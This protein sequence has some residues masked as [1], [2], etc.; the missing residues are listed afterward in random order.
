MTM[1]EPVKY[2]ASLQKELMRQIAQCAKNKEVLQ[3][4]LQQY[5]E[6]YRAGLLNQET[7]KQQLEKFLQGKPASYWYGLYE[8]HINKCHKTL[9]YC[10]EKLNDL[11]VDEPE[12]RKS[13][14]VITA[15]ALVALFIFVGVIAFLNPITTITGLFGF[16]FQKE[17]VVFEDGYTTEG[18]KWADIKGSRVY[19]RCLKIESEAPFS[20]VRV[21]GKITSAINRDDLT[22]NLYSNNKDEPGILLGSCTVKDYDAVWKFCSIKKLQQDKGAYWICAAAPGGEREQTYYTI[23]YSIGDNKKTALWTGQNWQKLERISYTLKA[24]FMDNE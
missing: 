9:V 11:A 4:T 19:E 23:A 16:E 15:I 21:L 13:P 8:D 7:Y 18:A 6:Q 1:I 10:T 12:R 24:Q 22:F 2:Y 17:K 3:E 5:T 14:L 20:S